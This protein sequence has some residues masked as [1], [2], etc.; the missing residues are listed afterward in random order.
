MVSLD[1]L[2]DMISGLPPEA[3]A[4]LLDDAMRQLARNKIADYR[5]Y[6]KQR[7]FHLLGATM[8]ERL[9]RAGNQCVTP[10]TFIETADGLLRSEEA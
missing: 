8:R 3:R 6:P 10:W 1:K 7:K 9:L 2:D 5:P 4:A